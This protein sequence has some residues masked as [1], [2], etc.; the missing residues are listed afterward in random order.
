MLSAIL[1]IDLVLFI[2]IALWVF[3]I[4][5][6]GTT[7]QKGGAGFVAFI[8]AIAIIIANVLIGLASLMLNFVWS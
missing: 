1:Y 4:N 7:D 3:V 6:T 5:I 8:L 2:L